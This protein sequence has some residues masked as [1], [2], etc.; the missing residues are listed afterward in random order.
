[1][2][3]FYCHNIEGGRGVLNQ[4]DSKH[5]SKVLRKKVGDKISVFDGKGG[6]HH[7]R[8]IEISRNEVVFTIE[9]TNVET[10]PSYLPVIGISILKNTNRLEWFLE[11][12]TE[13]G[14]ESIIPM[15]CDRTLKNKFRKDRAQSIV[16]SAMKQSLRTH[17]PIVKAEEKFANA[18]SNIHFEQKYICKYDAENPH[19]YDEIDPG[20]PSFILI[21]PEGDFSD[22]EMILAR[23]LGFKSVNISRSRLRT[24]T[25][26]ITA[27][28]IIA[29]K[30]RKGS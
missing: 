10:S 19:L 1:M 11:K 4:E 24:E 7:S 22:K 15:I 3:V 25:A 2:I 17:L 20:K 30:N 21:G 28:Q 14:V 8:I 18:I 6:V 5:C 26:G 13:I 16:I 9:K 27:C 29:L 12:A 23:S